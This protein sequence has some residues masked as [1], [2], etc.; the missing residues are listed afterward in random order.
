S[1]SDSSLIARKLGAV[2]FQL[3]ASPSLLGGHPV[4][5][6]PDQLQG[7]PGVLFQPN[8]MAFELRL[9]RNREEVSL[10]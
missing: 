8:R 6:H 10:Q 9:V 1:L 3:F 5:D 2:S 7:F 4:P